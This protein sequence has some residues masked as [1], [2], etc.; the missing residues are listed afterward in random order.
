ME[1]VDFI[2]EILDVLEFLK[3]LKVEEDYKQRKM[4]DPTIPEDEYIEFM[5]K[6]KSQIPITT[7]VLPKE[8]P[9]ISL[10]YA[11]EFVRTKGRKHLWGR[12]D[13]SHVCTG[14]TAHCRM[15]Y[16]NS[17]PGDFC[18]YKLTTIK[19][20]IVQIISNGQYIY[21]YIYNYYMNFR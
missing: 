16:G 12:G 15:I 17:S 19:I 14:V 7:L 4:L 21:I 1:F 5:P 11:W 18:Y 10:C 6:P 9:T 3:L 8:A 20:Y 13:N 2:F